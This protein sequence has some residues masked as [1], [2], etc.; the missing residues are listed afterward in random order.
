MRLVLRFVWMQALAR[1]ERRAPVDQEC[2]LGPR[3]VPIIAASYVYHTAHLLSPSGRDFTL[4][5]GRPN[6]M[7]F[8][9]R[10]EEAKA[11]EQVLAE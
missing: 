9:E 1:C 10:E 8:S 3:Q 11:S 4:I 5:S 6:F 7:A 2:I